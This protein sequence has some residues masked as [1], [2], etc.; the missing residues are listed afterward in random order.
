VNRLGLI[1]LLFS[2]ISC[3]SIHFKTDN[4]TNRNTIIS[5]EENTNHNEIVNIKVEKEFFLWGYFPA[6]EIEIDKELAKLGHKSISSFVITQKPTA[7]DVL[8]TFLTFGFYYPQTFYLA[9]K[10]TIQ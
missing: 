3:S 2:G 1:I 8:L 5:F 9:G 10:S 4:S 6:H 7:K